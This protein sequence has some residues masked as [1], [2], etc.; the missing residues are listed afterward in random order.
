M[1]VLTAYNAWLES[2]RREHRAPATVRQYAGQLK[3]LT[4]LHGSR[5][6]DSLTREEL[7]NWIYDQQHWA[8][9]QEKSG[10]TR[11]MVV[12]AL[13][14][15]LSFCIEFDY[16]TSSPLKPTDVKKPPTGQRQLLP[17][18][19][20][21]QAILK[22]AEDRPDWRLLYRA[23]RLTGCRPSELIH[24]QIADLDWDASPP[25]LNL[26]QHKTVRKTGARMIPLSDRVQSIV[27]SAIG[28]RQAGPVFVTQQGRKWG[29]DRPSELF[30]MYR[31]ACGI[32]P[33]IVLYTT[34]HEFGT[35]VVQNHGIAA[36]KEL[37]GHTSVTTTQR[38]AHLDPQHLE[39]V[40]RSAGDQLDQQ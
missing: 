9:G 1:N 34:R 26:R 16:L 37:L 39:Q 30:R 18:A 40:Q 38:Y 14:N 32:S 23:L 13:Q 6:L 24:A 33:E 21:V 22:A 15:F 36:G 29:R 20:Q 3:S 27:R 35:N 7:R 12:I 17:T 8:D 4:E 31:D 25:V 2:K 28:N 11:R 10:S 19:D 5:A